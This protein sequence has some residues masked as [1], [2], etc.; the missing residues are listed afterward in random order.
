MS[1][2]CPKC[3]TE[4]YD[5]LKYCP[6]CGFDF[7][8]ALKRCPKCRNH[9]PAENLTCPECGLNFEQFSFLIPRVVVFGTV[10]LIVVFALIFPW[11]WKA[12][13]W[14]HDKGGTVSGQVMSEVDGFPMVPLFIHWKSGERYIEKSREMGGLYSDTSYM[15]KLIPLPPE[16]VFHY[17]IPVGEKVWIIRRIKG[18]N[19]NW[20][21]IGRWVDKKNPAKYGW[22]HESD[23]E[24]IR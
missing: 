1:Y 10:G 16:V 20:V 13:P 2:T 4:F 3:K 18:T 19:H 11:L 23:I 8:A 14:M 15:N 22:I 6:E 9:V 5:R 17:D 24:T 21:Q 12:S 7:T